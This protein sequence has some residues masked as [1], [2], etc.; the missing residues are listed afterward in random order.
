MLRVHFTGADL[1]RTRVVPTP[2]PL[3]EAVL[4]LH[5]LR[6]QRPDADLVAWQRATRSVLGSLA[7]RPGL[8]RLFWLVP[9]RGYFPDFLTPAAGVH[10]I[11]EGID[12]V[13]HTPRERVRTDLTRLAGHGGLRGWASALARGSKTELADLATSLRDYHN[14]AV[15]PHLAQHTET[16]TAT[17]ERHAKVMERGGVGDLFTG[18]TPLFRWRWPVLEAP[19]PLDKDVHLAGRGLLLVPSVFCRRMP[20]TFADP[21]LP[22]VLVYPIT[23]A[24]TE[25]SPSL[26]ALLGRTRA[27]VLHMLDG[28]CTTSEIATRLAI[29]AASASEHATVLR[30]AGLIST[31]RAAQSVRH[32][33]TP[34]GEALLHSS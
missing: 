32:T 2:D 17:Q 12:E 11:D 7:C 19:Y 8:D 18:L 9:L 26:T 1:A 33:L 27:R 6:R 22:P 30:N 23:T 28:H 21:G 34:L 10:G 31:T 14:V 25:P 4:S 29:S 3:W 16:L 15:A 20:V 5:Q 24:D 13:L